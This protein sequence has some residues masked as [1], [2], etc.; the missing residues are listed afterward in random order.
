MVV[1]AEHFN[2]RINVYNQAGTLVLKK[3]NPI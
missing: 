1:W 2:V 3:N